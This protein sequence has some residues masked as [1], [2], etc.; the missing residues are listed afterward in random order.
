MQTGN[1]N[2][3]YKSDLDKFFFQHDMGYG[4]HKNLTKI[5]ESDKTL[6]DKAFKIA[7]KPKYDR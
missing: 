2:Y 5:T 4:K 6:R 3:I 7:S 1:T